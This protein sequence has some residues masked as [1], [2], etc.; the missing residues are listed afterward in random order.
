[1]VGR[2]VLMVMGAGPVLE[3]GRGSSGNRELAAAHRGILRSGGQ[4]EIRDPGRGGLV[5]GTCCSYPG[6]RRCRG[7]SG[8]SGGRQSGQPGVRTPQ[9]PEPHFDV[10]RVGP[11]RVAL[12]PVEGGAH[13]V[14]GGDPVGEPDEVLRGHRVLVGPLDGLQLPP[15][16][17]YGRRLQ[18]VQKNGLQTLPDG[19]TA[20]GFKSLTKTVS[21]S[22]SLACNSLMA[23]SCLLTSS[24]RVRIFSST[25]PCSKAN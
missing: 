3:L 24:D 16:L 20:T 15:G 4:P 2:R 9:E 19:S 17:E 21:A 10:G 14:G 12:L 8:G 18:R 6:R 22:F 13:G 5:R 11:P 23:S 7:G 1:M 25:W